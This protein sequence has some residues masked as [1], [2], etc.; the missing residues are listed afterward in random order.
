[1]NADISQS[2][3]YSFPRSFFWGSATASYQVEGGISNNDW[4]HEALNGKLPKCDKATNHYELF[5][6]DFDI[7]QSL[8]H[9][10]HRFSIEWSRIEPSPGNFDEREIEHYKKVLAAL[11]KK[12]PR[13]VCY[14][15]AFYG[16]NMV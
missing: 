4:A 5:E 15:V 8:H 1:M 13:T 14:F 2:R 12:R 11:K 6:A 9:N 3:S 16:A 7:A 10:A